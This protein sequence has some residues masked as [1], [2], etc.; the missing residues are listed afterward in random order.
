MRVWLRLAFLLLLLPWAG[1]AQD[2][3][4]EPDP[5]TRPYEVTVE[6]TGNGALDAAIAAASRLV[7]LQE[8]APT[9][10][11]GLLARARGD[12]ERVRAALDSEGFFAGTFRILVA[13]QDPTTV[14]FRPPP[15]GTPIPVAISTTPG[16]RYAITRVTTR[17]TEAEATAAR[18]A[19]PLQDLVGEPARGANVVEAQSSL[20]ERLQA[21]GHPFAKVEARDVVV[22]HDRQAMEIA[23]TLDPGPFARF[24]NSEV[25]GTQRVNERFVRRYT[26]RRLT[27]YPFDPARVSRARADL[28]ALGVFDSV[29]LETGDAL[30][31]DGRLPVSV[32]VSERARRAIGLNAAYETRFGIEL[33]AFFEH[34]NLFGNAE[35]LRLEA[36]ATRLGASDTSRTGGRLGFT[37]RDPFLFNTDYALVASLFLLRERLESYDRDALV[38]SFLAERKLSDRLTI[39]TGPVFEIGQSGPS[40]GTLVPNQVVGWQLG[41]RWDS[42][43]S[44]LDP[45]RGIRAE[46]TLT[47]SY[48][49]R[50]ANPYLRV[51]ASA[52]T[53][54]DIDGQGR[55]ILALRASYGQLLGTNALSVPISQRFFAGGGG[56]V[57]GYDFQSISPRAP[58]TRQRIGGTSLA[59]ASVEFRQRFGT[60]WG[61]VV[62]VDGGRVGGGS[63][64]DA[65][66]RL[67]TGVGVRYYTALGPIRA[68]IAIPLVKQQGSQGYGLYIGIGHAF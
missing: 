57:R 30:G 58:G 35:R 19:A 65:A 23:F 37:F 60:N 7:A 56:S 40:R 16:P 61:G 29:R 15:A 67:G 1:F 49:V 3:P 47:P 68:D 62:F 64:G 5:D 12:A 66:W 39:N 13:G 28:T 21:A 43:D 54:F 20:V 24:G 50:D 9:D 53:Y 11:P 6:P 38:G 4:E 25:S 59:E 22:D 8:R 55:S 32:A 44:L 52:S 27:N 46:A 18:A 51:R 45:R 34:R 48:S 33:G 2:P 31:P 17:A 63:G 36:A 26:D 14:E 10:V 42:T 41:A